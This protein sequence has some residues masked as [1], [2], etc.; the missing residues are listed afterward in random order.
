MLREGQ[1]MF[2]DDEEGVRTS[3][4][5]YFRDRG[6][7]TLTAPDGITA[8]DRLSES[9]V[10]VV[11][12]DMRMPGKNGLELQEWLQAKYPDTRF[13]MLTGYGDRRLEWRTRELGA[14]EY[15]EK[16]VSP[17]V[18]AHAIDRALDRTRVQPQVSFVAIPEREVGV[19]AAPEVAVEAE[20][21]EA[22]R[23][24]PAVTALGI[25]AAP[26]AGLAFVVFLPVIGIGAMVWVV[27]KRIIG[28]F[29]QRA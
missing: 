12:S 7:L 27:S 28:L 23:L 17:D 15:L 3:W 8:I 1:V 11:V 25:V 5:R 14:V 29:G 18:L 21:V 22:E 19:E 13:I 10:D 9:P 16:P 26:I 2:V 20:V 6:L 24:S 4:E